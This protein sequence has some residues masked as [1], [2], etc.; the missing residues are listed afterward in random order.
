MTKKKSPSLFSI[1]H[2]NRD[3]E[4][5]KHRSPRRFIAYQYDC[6]NDTYYSQLYYRDMCRLIDEV[7]FKEASDPYLLFHFSDRYEREAY[8]FLGIAFSNEIA[9]TAQY[10]DLA[11]VAF[12][13]R[14]GIGNKKIGNLIFS[15]LLKQG[16]SIDDIIDSLS[17]GS[18]PEI[19]DGEYP[20]L[21]RSLDSLA[22][23][24]VDSS[25]LCRTVS[26]ITIGV[27]SVSEA[28]CLFA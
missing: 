13:Q 14:Y 25:N 23:K 22:K 16:H 10:H 21:R 19:E 4:D 24:L 15:R 26:E 8:A 9:I 11:Y 7:D 28:S 12:T 20:H 5:K 2:Y 27:Q 17:G 1:H 6:I 3:E 18:Y